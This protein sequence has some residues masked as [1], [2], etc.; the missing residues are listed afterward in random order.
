MFMAQFQTQLSLLG[1]YSID[2]TLLQDVVE[3]ANAFLDEDTEIEINFSGAHQLASSSLP[4]VLQDSLLRTDLI[5][6]VAI[7][8]ANYRVEPK[9]V[10][11]FEAQSE[12]MSPTIS[13]RLSGNQEP[14]RSLSS[15]IE[16]LLKAKR[17]WYSKLVPGPTLGSVMVILAILLLVVAVA[18]GAAFIFNPSSMQSVGQIALVSMV[19]W[20]WPLMWFSRFLFPPL[21]V[22]I[23]R[24]A[25]IASQKRGMQKAIFGGVFGALMI[26]IAASLV[27]NHLSK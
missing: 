26:G 9:R 3:H 22:E 6:R 4:D 7:T 14:C 8:G 1:A 20:F 2:A 27:A 23:G 5:T 16:G 12:P 25:E 15:H 21:I 10:F 18:M 19:I 17:Q 11:N 24:S 13:V